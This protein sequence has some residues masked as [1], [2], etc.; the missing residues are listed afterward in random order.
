MAFFRLF[1]PLL[2]HRRSAQKSKFQVYFG[3]RNAKKFVEI[4]PL[5]HVTRYGI[6][7]QAL[8]EHLAIT[9]HAE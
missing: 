1:Y 2:S 5:P 6:Y 3:V 4:Y 9:C 7:E 8:R